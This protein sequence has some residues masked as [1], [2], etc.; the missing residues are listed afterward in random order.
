ADGAIAYTVS[1]FSGTYSYTVTGPT[2]IAPQSGISTDPLNFSGLLAGD[3]TITVT[4]DTTNCTDT[5]TVTVNEPAT[6]LAFTFTLN[7][8]TCNADGSVMIT[9]SDGWGGYTYELVQPDATVLGPQANNF[10]SG[11]SVDGTY[12][13]RVTDGGGC[14]VTDTF[15][16]NPP[17]NPVASI[18]FAAST[19]CFTSSGLATIVVDASLGAAPYYYSING[20]PTQTSDTFADLTPAIYDF[21]VTDSNGCT[22]TVQF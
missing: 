2:A 15:D 4:D 6:S 16:I 7:P 1:G 9:A 10:F 20:G 12:T 8:K 3:Y 14:T 22:G 5:A 11:L 21:T 19:L 18:D 13:I 17:T